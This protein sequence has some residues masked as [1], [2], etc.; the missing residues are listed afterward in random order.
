MSDTRIPFTALVD[1]LPA[2][3]PFVGPETLERMKQAW[4]EYADRVGVVQRPE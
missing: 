3:V 4:M 1:S 2:S